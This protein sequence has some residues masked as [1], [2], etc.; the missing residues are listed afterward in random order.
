M[1]KPKVQIEQNPVE[2][3]KIKPQPRKTTFQEIDDDSLVDQFLNN[4]VA[5]PKPKPK[6]EK[7]PKQDV[8]SYTH[9]DSSS[10]GDNIFG[11]TLKIES[12]MPLWKRGDY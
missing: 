6:E 12:D 5:P 1:N 10:V 11:Y 8:Y 7:M 2:Q 3:S 9:H 4:K